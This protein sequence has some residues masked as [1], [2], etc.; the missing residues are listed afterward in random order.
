MAGISVLEW[1]IPSR[2]RNDREEYAR[3]RSLVGIS[4]VILAASLFYMVKFHLMGAPAA[5]QGLALSATAA[6]L[7]PVVLR[8]TGRLSPARELA[9]AIIW[10]IMF[11]LCYVNRGVMSSEIFWFVQ[12]PCGAVL[13]GDL[14]H[15]FVWLA[16]ALLGIALVNFG[17]THPLEQMPAAALRELQ[18]SSA[19]GLVISLFTV[20]AVSERH[21]MRS[22]AKLEEAR[23]EAARQSERQREM[24][25]RVSSLIHEDHQAIRRITE[26]MEEVSR[27]IADQQQAFRDSANALGDLGAMVAQNTE[28]AERS[29]ERA[30][31][32]ETQAL[33][34]GERMASTLQTLD[35]L[36]SSS[37]STSRTISAL[38]A[39]G[40]QI[41][42]IVQ[43]IEEIANQ[44]NLLA[45]N[46][47]IE[48]AHAGAHGKGFA[49]VA[50]EVRKLAERTQQATQ[51]IGSQIGDVVKGTQEA[52]T[53]LS[54]S[55]ARL[56]ASQ[57]D[58]RA[59]AE[60]LAG[61]ITASQ[62]A[63]QRIGDMAETSQRQRSA[64]GL[65]ASA[66]GGMREATQTVSQATEDV[67]RALQDLEHQLDALEGFLRE[68]EAP[69]A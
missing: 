61:I 50:E 53:T 17:V 67:G 47:A 14:R 13:L 45:L 28:N 4:C 2:L 48:A 30:R 7:V 35:E 68:M 62:E 57:R 21:K 32:A 12:V 56:D 9:L 46:A 27:A 25:Q 29:A 6:F 8:L 37:A 51:E 52:N 66:F 65:V 58:A 1:W 69:G 11:W 26:N 16:L 18:F 20:L 54:A 38:G 59:L 40:D 24:L 39:K 10:G 23:A 60:A 5:V 34:G 42:S 31:S 33:D 15:G 64:S 55:G 22:A 63:A 3:A 44:T 36:V 41:G 49:V 19:M 43:V